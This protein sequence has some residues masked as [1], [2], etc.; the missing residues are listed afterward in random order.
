MATTGT[1]SRTNNLTITHTNS[2][3]INM[4]AAELLEQYQVVTV[5]DDAGANTD[6][7]KAYVD[8]GGVIMYDY[9]QHG[10]ATLQAFGVT[11]DEIPMI[12]DNTQRTIDVKKI[13]RLIIVCLAT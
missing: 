2:T 6:L 5:A 12:S 1:Y 10:W 11:V 9:H 3:T 13:H 4:T 8:L 7:L